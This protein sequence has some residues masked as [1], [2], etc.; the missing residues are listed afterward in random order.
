VT[1]TDLAVQ[2]RQAVQLSTDQLQYIAHTEF[3]PPGLRGNLP[4]ILACVAT[5]RELGIGDMV[6]LKSI[7]VID[8]KPSFSAELCVL[9]VRRQGHSITGE[10]GP[11]SCTVYGR[12]A[13]NGDEISVTWT[14]EMA[15]QAGLLGKQ[16]WQ[17]YEPSMLW[18]RAVTQL[19][20]MLFADC[21]AGATYT[22]EELGEDGTLS[23][24]GVGPEPVPENAPPLI[25]AAQKKKADVLVGQL[26]DQ[27]RLTTEEIFLAAGKEPA[28]YYDDH[29][30][31]RWSWLRDEL[32]KA[33]ASVLIDRLEQFDK[34]GEQTPPWIVEVVP[35]TAPEDPVPPSVE[36]PEPSPLAAE[37]LDLAGDGQREAWAAAVEA[38]R[39]KH[40]DEPAAHALWL[41]NQIARVKEA[42]V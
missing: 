11:G 40:I 7:H 34:S 35:Q 27:L 12:R 15:K 26:R 10:F 41:D 24:A 13:D 8:G 37:L 6:S 21:F 4:A 29:G 22:P 1:S 2:T 14:T 30:R 19:C 9:L 25:T 32:T 5:G 31:L 36:L 16:N 3:V 18:A 20:R 28:R 33:E 23:G 39:L 38:N 17:K 42:A